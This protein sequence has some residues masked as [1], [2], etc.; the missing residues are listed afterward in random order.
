MSIHTYKS[1]ESFMDE[2]H[3]FGS[4]KHFAHALFIQ[5]CN[6]KTLNGGVDMQFAGQWGRA[7]SPSW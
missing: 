1:F 5:E 4:V 7:V 6:I 3:F 2:L